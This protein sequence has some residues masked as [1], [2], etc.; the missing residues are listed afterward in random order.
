LNVKYLIKK[1]WHDPVWSKVIAGTILAVAGSIITSIYILIQVLIEKVPIIQVLKKILGFFSSNTSI[2]NFLLILGAL[3]LLYVISIFLWRLYLKLFQEEPEPKRKSIVL[4]TLRETSTSFFSQRISAAFPGQ[5]AVIWY[6]KPKEIVERLKIVFAPP[7][8]FSSNGDYGYETSSQPIWW[9]RGYESTSI[10][11]FKVLSNSKVLIGH[12]EVEIKRIA[13][14]SDAR[15]YKCFIYIE[16]KAEK[17]T[18]V[19]KQFTPDAIKER[20]KESGLCY[21]EYAMFG[22]IPISRTEYDDGGA[23]IK[24][25]I[26]DTRLKADFRIRY[27]S[28]YNFIIAAAHSPYNS[29]KFNHN[30]KEYFDGILSDKVSLVSFFNYLDEFKRHEEN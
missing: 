26:Y 7:I 28:E 15:Y 14:N 21:E 20:V 8:H 12:H 30:S 17:P 27:L 10:T 1:N 29:K 3:V 6:D 13:V 4:P 18:G 5:R 9:L 19:Y 22:K 11:Q 23:V 16:C 25:R 2:N 24:G